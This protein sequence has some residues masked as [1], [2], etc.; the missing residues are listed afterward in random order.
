MLKFCKRYTF[1]RTRRDTV[2]TSEKFLRQHVVLHI[3]KR[4]S[5]FVG[6]AIGIM[7]VLGQSAAADVDADDSVLFRNFVDVKMSVNSTSPL[8]SR[9]R[10]SLL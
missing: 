8:S 7:P 3:E 4:H 6:Y 5:L 10:L 9:G 2:Q 1:L